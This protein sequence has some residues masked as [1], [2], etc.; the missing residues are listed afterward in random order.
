MFISPMT[1]GTDILNAQRYG[2]KKKEIWSALP[3]NQ[4]LW[5]VFEKVLSVVLI[6]MYLMISSVA[7]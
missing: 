2:Y 1:Q 7:H 5:K 4:L 3:F 6:S